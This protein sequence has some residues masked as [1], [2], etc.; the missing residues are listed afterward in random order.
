MR[1]TLGPAIDRRWPISLAVGLILAW[2]VLLVMTAWLALKE[3]P[4]VPGAY[5]ALAVAMG[6]YLLYPVI[7]GVVAARSQSP[8]AVLAAGWIAAFLT[9]VIG[10]LALF[11]EPTRPGLTLGLGRTG[12]L[13]GAVVASGALYY[14][15]VAV[16]RPSRNRLVTVLKAIGA[17]LLTAIASYAMLALV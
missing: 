2:I 13:L 4:T 7:V 8:R 12:A 15:S 1:A 6:V 17:M 11:P 10:A 5:P 16:A 14:A 9:I 3:A